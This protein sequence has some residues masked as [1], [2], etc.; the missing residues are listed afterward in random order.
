M[1]NFLQGFLGTQQAGIEARNDITVAV[2]TGLL[3]ATRWLPD[4]R[5]SRSSGLTS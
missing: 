5:M 1:S 2:P 3:I 4:C